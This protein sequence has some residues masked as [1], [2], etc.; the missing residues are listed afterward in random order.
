MKTILVPSSLHLMMYQHLLKSKKYLLDVQLLSLNSFVYENKEKELDILYQFQQK[1]KWISKSNSYYTSFDDYTFLKDCLNF[2]RFC[3]V[4][5]IH[6]F[7]VQNQKEKD[8]KEILDC[9]YDIDLKENHKK[10]IVNPDSVWILSLPFSDIEMIWIK[11]LI[12]KGAHY[13]ETKPNQYVSYTSC[14]NS[15]KEAQWICEQ[16]IDL[17]LDASDCM[18]CTNTE[19]ENQVLAQMLDLFKIPYTFLNQVSSSSVVREFYLLFQWILQ[20]DL[21]S[22]L[23]MVQMVFPDDYSYLFTYYSSFPSSFL[24]EDHHLDSIIYQRNNLIKEVDFNHLMEAYQKSQQWIV[25]HPS[26]FSLTIFD[27]EEITQIIQNR[28]PFYNEDDIQAYQEVLDLYQQALPYLNHSSLF[29]QS[30]ENCRVSKSLKEIKGVCIGSLKDCN[31]LRA[32]TFIMGAHTKNFPNIKIH[33]NLFNE[34]YIRHTSLPSL[35]S[36]LSFQLDALQQTLQHCQFLYISY[37]QS[38]YEGKNYE[39]SPEIRDWFGIDAK[40]MNPKESSV[41]EKMKMEISEEQAQQLFFTK[42]RFSVSLLESFARCPFSHYLSYGLHLKQ[43]QNWTDITTKGTI[44]HSILEKITQRYQKEYTS[45]SKRD[46]EYIV[47]CEFDFLLRVYPHQ[48]RWVNQQILDYVKQVELVLDQLQVFEKNWHM[49]IHQQEY[50]IQKEWDF[51]GLTLSFVGYVDRIDA[52]NSS[53]CIFD[54]KSSKKELKLER[55]QSGLSLQ[56]LTYTIYIQE[57]TNLHPVGCFYISMRSPFI[58]DEACQISYP[59]ENHKLGCVTF[60]DGNQLDA[61]IQQKMI[62]GWSFDGFENYIDDDCQISIPRKRLSYMECKDQWNQIINGLLMDMKKGDISSHHVQNACS[63]CSFMRICR[64][65][66]MEVDPKNYIE[67]EEQ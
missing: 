29:L 63:L 32:H 36:R 10:E 2:I 4:Y 59:K 9:L 57:K 60:S 41:F 23:D 18:I 56:L 45:I 42:N 66:R 35:Q 8:L 49:S 47:A 48:K 21:S 3:K 67:K 13:F 38:N 31:G 15:R 53:F 46:I 64:N 39:P 7:P 44:L 11:E 52:S 33:N 62:C 16:I 6:S 51:D 61:Y 12:R 25:Q 28:H 27:I 17:D 65:N 34:D 26:I 30:L 58:Q 54:Y 20:H 22:F 55:F 40:F 5:E 1:K 19:S 43:P 24:N 37:P 50:R 14:A